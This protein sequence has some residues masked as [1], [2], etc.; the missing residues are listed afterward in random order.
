M[1]KKCILVVAAVVMMAFSGLCFAHTSGGSIYGLSNTDDGQKIIIYTSEGYSVAS[2]IEFRVDAPLENHDVIE[3]LDGDYL[4]EIGR[5]RIK[6]MH[7]GSSRNIIHIE[8]VNLSEKEALRW[9]ANGG[10]F[11]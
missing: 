5:I 7:N 4:T 2:V 1:M 3:A 10:A 11:E 8:G 9:L 6:D